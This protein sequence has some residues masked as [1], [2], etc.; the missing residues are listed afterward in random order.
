MA[1]RTFVRM[2]SEHVNPKLGGIVG[3]KTAFSTCNDDIFF[4]LL[5][6]HVLFFARTEDD[7]QRTGFMLN[8]SKEG[9]GS[10]RL[11]DLLH[12]QIRLSG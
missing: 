7:F 6:F 5:F 12:R 11:F 9:R 3:G 10:T 8:N 1:V 4:L 2:L